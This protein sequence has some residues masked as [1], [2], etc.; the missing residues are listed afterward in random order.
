MIAFQIW[1]IVS[2]IEK[3]FFVYRWLINEK[4]I[5][6]L[7]VKFW[8][9]NFSLFYGQF[10]QKTHPKSTSV[11]TLIRLKYI[12]YQKLPSYTPKQEANTTIN[13]QNE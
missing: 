4:L 5:E 12:K 6:N 2:V 1:F 13:Y 9:V 8:K 3:K 11:S 7:S 10:S